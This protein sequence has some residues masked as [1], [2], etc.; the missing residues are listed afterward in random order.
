MG[1]LRKF[2]HVSIAF[3]TGVADNSQFFIWESIAIQR[4]LV[5]RNPC[6]KRHVLGEEAVFKSSAKVLG[7]GSSVRDN[8]LILEILPHGVPVFYILH[9]Y[10]DVP[11]LVINLTVT[12]ACKIPETVDVGNLAGYQPGI[13]PAL[14]IQC[15]PGLQTKG[16]CVI[17]APLKWGRG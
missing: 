3:G 8:P 12:L 9:G 16:P 14:R 1:S 2:S 5:N 13:S 15:P 10:A 7:A 17:P 4:E 6:D 11:L